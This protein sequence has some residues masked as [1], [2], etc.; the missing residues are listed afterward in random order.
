[1]LIL[2]FKVVHDY[3]E[4]VGRRMRQRT[5]GSLSQTSQ[6]KLFE[7]PRITHL[8]IADIYIHYTV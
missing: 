3:G 7:S 8:G 1:M 4:E 6:L 5:K 2:Q